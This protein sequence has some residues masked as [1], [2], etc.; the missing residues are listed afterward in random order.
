M[1]SITRGEY[2]GPSSFQHGSLTLDVDRRGWRR[3]G[4]WW[5]K[6]KTMQ[7]SWRKGQRW[8]S[9]SLLGPSLQLATAWRGYNMNWSFNTAKFIPGLCSVTKNGWLVH[10]QLKSRF[11]ITVCGYPIFVYFPYLFIWTVFIALLYSY[12]F[13]IFG[14]NFGCSWHELPSYQIWTTKRLFPLKFK[15]L[16]HPINIASNHITVP[17]FLVLTAL[18]PVHVKCLVKPFTC[19]K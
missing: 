18:V 19:N 15:I 3:V 11:L 6:L 9:V 2:E 10:Y 17:W 1:R 16:K 12:I 14:Y 7:I 8:A 5:R 13:S 4:K